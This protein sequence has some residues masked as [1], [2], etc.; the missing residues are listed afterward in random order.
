MFGTE[1]AIML[2]NDEPE[3]A[4]ATLRRIAEH[5]AAYVANEMQGARY[6]LVEHGGGTASCTVISPKMFSEFCMPYD[7]IV[8]DA[9]H[10]A[11]HK[12]V[13]HTCGGMRRILDRIPANGTD[14]SET[15]SPPG[16]GG[17]IGEADRTRVKRELGSMVALIGGI[18]QHHHLTLGPPAE[19]ERAVENCFATYGV[20]GGY[21]CSAS[22][23]FFDAPVAN[24]VAMAKAGERCRY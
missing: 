9:L 14:V 8:I 19:V 6:D 4:H 13:Y 17:N 2:V 7:R 20:G 15:L 16:V 3:W 18:D 21:I 5:K 12:V 22:D 11:G 24:L 23:H 1:H 10:A